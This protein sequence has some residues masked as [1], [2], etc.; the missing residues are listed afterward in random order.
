MIAAGFRLA[1]HRL[2][3]FMRQHLAIARRARLHGPGN[4]GLMDPPVWHCM[5]LATTRRLQLLQL[6]DSQRSKPSPTPAAPA[7]P[8]QLDLFA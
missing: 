6:I 3:I 7:L 1:H 8:A 4:G 2:L 5:H